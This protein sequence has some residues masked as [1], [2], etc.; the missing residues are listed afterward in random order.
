MLKRVVTLFL[1]I[2]MLLSSVQ[3]SAFA[4]NNDKLNEAITEDSYFSDSSSEDIFV[5]QI[6]SDE[7][8]FDVPE[9]E[10][11]F[12]PAALE[13]LKEPYT[14]ID[15]S[16]NPDGTILTVSEK[17]PVNGTYEIYILENGEIVFYFN[18]SS[19]ESDYKDIKLISDTMY[20]ISV[21]V[22]NGNIRDSY[23]G[24]FSVVNASIVYDYIFHSTT[25]NNENRSV[26]PL[27]ST[28]YESESNNTYSSAD[29]LG[30]GNTM[31]GCINSANDRDWYRI[32]FAKDGDAVFSLTNIPNGTD[33][34]MTIYKASNTYST[35]TVLYKCT[36]TGSINEN[37]KTRIDSELYYYVE[38]FSV[39]G[40]TASSYYY[41]TVKNTPITDQYEVNDTTAKATP[42]SS[43]GTYYA[44]IHDSKD[45]DYYKLTLSSG[46]RVS[47][48]LANIP[49]GTNYDLELYNSSNSKLAG[50][51]NTGTTNENISQALQ[52]GTYYIKVF[53]AYGSSYTSNYK[54]SIVTASNTISVS[55]TINP[56]IPENANSY[57]GTATAIKNLPIQLYSVN[58]QN[59]TTLVSEGT[60]DSLGKYSKSGINVSGDVKAIRIQVLFN[61][62]EL[63]V[64]RTNGEYYSFSY[65]IPIGTSSSISVTLPNQTTVPEEQ[66]L[67]YALWKNGMDCISLHKSISSV[68]LGKLEFRS[69][70][71]VDGTYC[72]S[73]LLGN[74]ISVGG[75]SSHKAYLNKDVILH[76]IGHWMMYKQGLMPSGAGG[77]HGYGSACATKGAA[78]AE[79]W[80]TFYSCAARNSAQMMD[81]FSSS[82]SN[83]GAN[84]SSAQYYSSG[85]KSLPL[86]STPA[87]NQMYE[88]NVGSILWSY[89]NYYNYYSTQA[90]TSPRKGS[91]EDIY[92]SAISSAVSSTAKEAV[93]KMFNDRGCAFDTTVPTVNLS[94]TG[95]TALASASDDVAVKKLVWLVN[96]IQV[97]TSD[98]DSDSL[99]LS[100]YPGLVTVEVRAYDL[101]GLEDR[102]WPREQRYATNTSTVYIYSSTASY[103]EDETVIIDSFLPARVQQELRTEQMMDIGNAE[104]YSIST[105]GERDIYISAHIIGGV[106]SID[107]YDPNG[108]LFDTV[109]YI[110]PDNPYIVKRAMA[111][112]WTIE[113]VALSESDMYEILEMAELPTFSYADVND[114]NNTPTDESYDDFIANEEGTDLNDEVINDTLLNIDSLEDGSMLEVF[115]E[116][117]DDGADSVANSIDA[118]IP[119]VSFDNNIQDADDYTP[120][121]DVPAD[122]SYISED[123][124][125][126]IIE[127]SNTV[128]ETEASN[129][130]DGVVTEDLETDKEILPAYDEFVEKVKNEFSTKVAVVLSTKPTRIDCEDVVYTAN[131]LYLYDLL[132]T[133]TGVIVQ[134]SGNNIDYT[135]P[136]A[137]GYYELEIFRSID[138]TTSDISH[139]A[140]VVDTMAPEIEFINNFETNEEGIYLN[141]I[142]SEDTTGAWIDGIELSLSEFTDDPILGVYLELAIGKTEM[143][144]TLVDH[145]GNTSTEKLVFTRSA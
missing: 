49:S 116:P 55:C 11:D 35:P 136:L 83:Y 97:K 125:D 56:K 74:Y 131:S 115:E 29:I 73:S 12:S 78:Y 96:G 72:T 106:N 13:E 10:S 130:V 102:S 8:P 82:S 142:C 60:T 121:E 104:R 25:G 14:P 52:S 54:L 93:W 62:S 80:A 114:D 128:D 119:E 105:D 33:Y 124:T 122:K 91:L 57:N 139:M 44:N 88:L 18:S 141:G 3:I 120:D 38:V 70:V 132:S 45:V 67:A 79:G 1:T 19:R 34:N 46:G 75:L 90:L 63:C 92:E 110:S 27:A 108:D 42:I 5:E 138:G 133:R 24:Y 99:D 143:E 111:G 95:N 103:A 30:D 59:R 40:F 51:N 71:G 129:T 26:S 109:T 126:S 15:I 7:L 31:L 22:T 53:S 87:Q 135:Q 98:T 118:A 2:M 100:D 86:Q 39:R 69:S 6:E 43:S 81:Y 64:K 112:T 66:I 113:V 101:E 4:T 94:V 50:S 123:L 140:L 85:W 32:S 28:Q 65:D 17:Q 37:W 127:A 137:D 89:K 76:E 58:S 77:N 23:D 84:L 145:C 36:N 9:Q 41:L 20:F 117:P 134:E 61:N 21:V 48:S 68:Y 107:I 144:L 16:L 47:I